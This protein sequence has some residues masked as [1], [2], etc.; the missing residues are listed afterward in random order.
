MQ[1]SKIAIDVPCLAGA[2]LRRD[3]PLN[4]FLIA[5]PLGLMIWAIIALLWF[6]LR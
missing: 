2:E 5:I 1:Y 3:T 4:G 6:A